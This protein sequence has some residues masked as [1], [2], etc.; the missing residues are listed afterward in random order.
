MTEQVLGQKRVTFHGTAPEDMKIR[1]GAIYITQRKDYTAVTRV[2]SVKLP[3]GLVDQLNELV[4]KGFFQNR[5]DAVREAVRLLLAKY[6]ETRVPQPV[7][8]VR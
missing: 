6:K 2:I 3:V 4:E 5:S 1:K 8:G 7:P